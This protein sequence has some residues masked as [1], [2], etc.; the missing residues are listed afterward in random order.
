MSYNNKNKEVYLESCKRISKIWAF[1]TVLSLI[2]AVLSGP[3]MLL[4]L[5][6]FITNLCFFLASY[7]EVRKLE[8]EVFTEFDVENI[9]EKAMEEEYGFNVTTT[10]EGEQEFDFKD[11][12]SF[13]S[14]IN[15]VIER[16]KQIA[17]EQGVELTDN[18]EDVKNEKIENNDEEQINELIDDEDYSDDDYPTN[19]TEND[20]DLKL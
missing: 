2:S 3:L 14:L 1:T 8:G 16:A 13:N 4:R 20:E 9:E 12:E 6:G 17:E 15:M 5:S 10:K 7:Y 19:E 11:E 18:E